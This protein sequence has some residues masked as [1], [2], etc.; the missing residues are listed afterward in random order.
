MRGVVVD[1]NCTDHLHSSKKVLENGVVALTCA[2][3]NKTFPSGNLFMRAVLAFC[4]NDQWEPN[5]VEIPCQTPSSAVT[6]EACGT[7]AETPENARVA[8]TITDTSSVV[9]ANY[10]KCNTGMNWLSGR[11][12]HLTECSNGQ[13]TP[14]LD[15]CDEDCPV[16]RDCT[17]I[18]NFGF[19]QNETYNV[20][21]SGDPHQS[22]TEISNEYYRQ[23]LAQTL[24]LTCDQLGGPGRGSSALYG[25][26]LILQKTCGRPSTG[27]LPVSAV[28]S[29]APEQLLM[30]TGI[31]VLDW[32]ISR[33]SPT[34]STAQT[35]AL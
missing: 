29:L 14:I 4:Y 32:T 23:R 12:G 21:P 16:P 34:K 35:A 18:A 33:L 31:T 19:D 6:T 20:M 9:Y 7:N 24:G 2:D 27:F 22:K 25:V 5:E 3:T 17:D 15:K 10:Y 26:I 11:P 13:W 28:R 30:Q 1:A 8:E